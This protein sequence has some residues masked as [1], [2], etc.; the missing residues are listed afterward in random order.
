MAVTGLL[1]DKA[2]APAASQITDFLPVATS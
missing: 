1:A 2:N